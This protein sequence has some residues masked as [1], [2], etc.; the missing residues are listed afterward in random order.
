MFFCYDPLQRPPLIS[1]VKRQLRVR[2]IYKS[3]LFEYD[4]E[5]NL[6]VFWV[7]MV[8]HPPTHSLLCP[9][10]PLLSFSGRSA[11]VQWRAAPSDCCM[12]ACAMGA[13]SDL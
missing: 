6:V 13:P 9:S 7:R 4:A 1:A 12:S 3:K 5:R 10:P 2:T 8:G 11:L